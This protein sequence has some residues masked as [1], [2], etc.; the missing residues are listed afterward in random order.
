MLHREGRLVDPNLEIF[1]KILIEIVICYPS[2]IFI[3]KRNKN[4]C[5]YTCTPQV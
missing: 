4:K 1:Q 5:E 3:Q 2:E